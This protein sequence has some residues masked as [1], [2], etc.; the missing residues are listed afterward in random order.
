MEY[1]GMAIIEMYKEDYTNYVDLSEVKGSFEQFLKWKY[2][3]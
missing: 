2:Y 3:L 1:D